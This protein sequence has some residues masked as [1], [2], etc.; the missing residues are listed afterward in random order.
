[1]EKAE[2][3]SRAPGTYLANQMHNRH[4]LKGYNKMGEEILTQ[5]DGKV[6]AFVASFGSAGCVMGVAEVLKR[7]D[8]KTKVFI[9]EPSESPIMS[10]GRA[11]AHNLTDF[12]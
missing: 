7:K 5:L 11:G 10:K 12:Q 4:A 6:D 3:L 1:M 8:P 9:V 2:Q